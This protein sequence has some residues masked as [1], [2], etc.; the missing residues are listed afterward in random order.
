MSVANI[1]VL[2]IRFLLILVLLVTILLPLES[3]ATTFPFSTN[4]N[5]A[6]W[7]RPKPV[8]RY[9][10]IEY[11]PPINNSNAIKFFRS[12]ESECL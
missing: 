2:A 4:R 10:G 9:I 12:P 8:N 6:D 3:L 1:P 5:A 7:L 11:C